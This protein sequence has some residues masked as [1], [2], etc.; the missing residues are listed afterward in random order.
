MRCRGRWGSW[1]STH[2]HGRRRCI[3]GLVAPL[4]YI[5]AD[6][7]ERIVLWSP[8]REGAKTVTEGEVVYAFR[9][10][11]S[12]K[13]SEEQQEVPFGGTGKVLR[14]QQARGQL[15]R[16]CTY[17]V[18]PKDLSRAPRRGWPKCPNRLKTSH[19]IEYSDPKVHPG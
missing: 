10:I 12:G 1:A 14:S 4:T 16:S 8:R 13:R 15:K 3:R 6:Y 2:S 11:R 5:Y 19:L 9:S 17:S 18:P 7:V